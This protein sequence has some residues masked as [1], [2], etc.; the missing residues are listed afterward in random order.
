MANKIDL[1]ILT[2]VYNEKDE[3]FHSEK[4]TFTNFP[5]VLMDKIDELMIEKSRIYPWVKFIVTNSDGDVPNECIKQKVVIPI[6]KMKSLKQLNQYHLEFIDVIGSLIDIYNIDNFIKEDK[7]FNASM[8]EIRKMNEEFV[9][10]IK[11]NAELDYK[12][13]CMQKRFYK[14]KEPKCKDIESALN[15]PLNTIKE[16]KYK[17]DN[18]AFFRID[19]TLNHLNT[20]FWSIKREIDIPLVSKNSYNAYNNLLNGKCDILVRNIFDRLSDKKHHL[21]VD[22]VQTNNWALDEGGH[23]QSTNSINV[24]LTL[25]VN[26]TTLDTDPAVLCEALSVATEKALIKTIKGAD[27]ITIT[28]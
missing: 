10:L 16:I 17:I 18:S 7:E 1:T 5:K 4:N 19:I 26:I 14:F 20:P 12:F 9:N 8:N 23:L 13:E 3:I 27:P 15:K 21:V 25:D 22:V 2:E 6:S 24:K 28:F 11:E